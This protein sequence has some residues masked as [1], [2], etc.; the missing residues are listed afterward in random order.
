MKINT[1]GLLAS[2]LLVALFTA[3]SRP[4]AYFQPSAREHFTKAQ[5]AGV[6]PDPTVQTIAPE[7]V[8]TTT[9]TTPTPTQQVAQANQ[10]LDQVDALVRNDSKLAADKTVQKR[11]SRI[12][13]LLTTASAKVNLT[14]TET[15]APKKMNL[16]QRLML[17]KMDKKI[18]KQ[19]APANPNQPMAVKGILALGAVVLIAG[20]L[21]ALLATGTGSTI[22]VIGIIAGLALLLIG[23]I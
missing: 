19:L 18:S 2:L 3:C 4:V 21:L 13:N 20:I 14:P 12:R 8:V 7:Q 6:A 17:K 22:G 9:E 15:N 10:T 11:L 16:M 23:L 1:Q 5:S